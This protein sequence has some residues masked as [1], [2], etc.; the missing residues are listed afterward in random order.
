[1][2]YFVYCRKSTDS[3][4]RQ[5][6]S[7]SSQR[8]EIERAFGNSPDVSIAEVL[9]ESYSAK[10]PGR[11]VFDGMLKRIEKGEAEGIIAW[12]PDRLARNSLDGGRVIYLLDRGELKDLKF[13]TFSFEN[14][15]QGKFML[16]I[17][18]GYSKYYVD[19]L[20]ENIRRGNRAKIALGWRPNAAPLGYLNDKNTRTIVPDP[21]RF[22]LIRRLFELSLSGSHSLR[23]LREETQRWGFRT[24]QYRRIGGSYLTISGIH[25]ILTNPFYAGVLMWNNQAHRGAHQPVV[26]A[27]EFERVQRLLRRPGKPT[28]KYYDF[29]LTGLIRC[30][31]CGFMVTAETKVKAS[32]RRYTYY[33]CSK[34]RL[35]YRC[36]QRSVRA[37]DLETMV[38]A[39][40][41]RLSI[42]S[43]LHEFFLQSMADDDELQKQQ[44]LTA[45]RSMELALKTT[46]SW[47]GNLRRLQI[48]NPMPQRDFDAEEQK[49]QAEQ[50][51]LSEALEELERDTDRFELERSLNPFR[52]QAIFRYAE[53]DSRCKRLILR[54]V[55][56]NSTLKD[57]ILR[58]EA[59][60]P[61]VGVSEKLPCSYLRRGVNE[62]RTKYRWT[63]A[64][65]ARVRKQVDEVHLLYLKKD[66]ELMET[67]ELVEEIMRDDPPLSTR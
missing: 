38:K 1:V 10:A 64:D 36:K 59:K 22:E 15:S 43:H 13:S 27:D 61:F 66:P 35:D 5:I 37:E 54:A 46:E 45:K 20:S 9:E 53:G 11:P 58:I 55:G 29:P 33:H 48:R 51:R 67:L 19:S 65:L 21:E 41:G 31:E 2:R 8:S 16:S 40:L 57:R 32:G 30:G 6:L 3:E 18:F 49:I 60:K 62:V 28:P 39:A 14:N 56:S 52:K 26:T 42:S 34:R 50:R 23:A 63:R 44:R 12:H 24:R 25:R 4:D 7:I 47:H 17:V